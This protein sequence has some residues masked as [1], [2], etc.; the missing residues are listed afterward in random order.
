MPS[1]LEKADSSARLNSLTA[2]SC[3]HFE[4]EEEASKVNEKPTLLN[5]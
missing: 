4:D 2:S 1:M 3:E 5:N